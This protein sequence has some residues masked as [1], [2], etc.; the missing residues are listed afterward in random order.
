MI[1]W[2]LRN[3]G[4][5]FLLVL[6]AIFAGALMV[7]AVFSSVAH[8]FTMRSRARIAEA[9]AR[10][11]EAKT[12]RVRLRTAADDEGALIGEGDRRSRRAIPQGVTLG[13][14]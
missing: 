6:A 1:E 9:N 5:T 13:K 12:A 11:A 2:A 10:A 4:Y 8:P 14:G 7:E 3:P